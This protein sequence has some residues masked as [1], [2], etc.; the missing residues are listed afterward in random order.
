MRLGDRLELSLLSDLKLLFGE[1]DETHAAHLR[2]NTG[3]IAA[4]LISL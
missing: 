1:S 4:C 2:R 3:Q